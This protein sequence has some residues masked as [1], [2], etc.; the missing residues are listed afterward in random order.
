M[1]WC[2]RCA[3]NTSRRIRPGHGWIAPPL[4]GLWNQGIAKREPS[5][6]PW[7]QRPAAGLLCFDHWRPRIWHLLLGLPIKVRSD[8]AIAEVSVT[9]CELKGDWRVWLVGA[10]GSSGKNCKT[11][12]GKPESSASF[13]R[14]AR[15]GTRLCEELEWLLCLELSLPDFSGWHLSAFL[16]C[17]ISLAC[18]ILQS[19]QCSSFSDWV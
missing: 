12:M 9:L 1:L 15:S 11:A 6:S 10:S 18:P 17:W 7:L 13:L 14:P 5:T 3:P 2:G 8:W 16:A 19:V 4:S